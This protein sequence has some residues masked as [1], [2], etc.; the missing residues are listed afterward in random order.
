MRRTI[1]QIAME[2][3][4]LEAEAIQAN[5]NVEKEY[6]VYARIVDFAKL[7]AAQGSE[8]QEQWEIKVPHTEGNAGDGR[9]RVRKT[10]GKDGT[11]YV[12]T[13]KVRLP[14]TQTDGVITPVSDEQYALP[15][16]EK[17]HQLFAMIA[18]SGMHKE[19]YFF[20][21]DHGLTWEVDVFIKADG[22][23]A[24]WVKIDLELPAGMPGLKTLPALPEGFVDP[25]INQ[26]GART[27]EEEAKVRELYQTVFLTKNKHA[28][29]KAAEAQAA[30][31][32]ENSSATDNAGQQQEGA[33]AAAQDNGSTEQA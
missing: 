14:N 9:I 25:I 5:V 17:M 21:T 1:A 3:M 7:H 29:A 32:G 33:S 24:D 23:R 16:D 2:A 19:R 6:V 18:E 20:P 8:L 22:T 10:V 11:Q 26:D 30:Q 4:A 12:Q 28:A 31:S 15:V 27:D 13:V